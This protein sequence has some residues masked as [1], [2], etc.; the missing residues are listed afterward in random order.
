[1]KRQLLICVDLL[2]RNIT[3]GKLTKTD[4]KP[5]IFLKIKVQTV[6]FDTAFTKLDIITRLKLALNMVIFLFFS[7]Q[8]DL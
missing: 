6:L 5:Y 8:S 2:Q 3:S 7:V 1:M 4:D